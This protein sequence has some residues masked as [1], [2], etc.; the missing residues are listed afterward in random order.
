VIS[1]SYKFIPTRVGA[2]T[3]YGVVHRICVTKIAKDY[4]YS[5]LLRIL[6]A[7]QTLQSGMWDKF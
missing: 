4:K 7:V 1:H 2:G 3:L 6:W 5:S